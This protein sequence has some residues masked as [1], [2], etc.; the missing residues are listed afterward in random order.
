MLHVMRWSNLLSKK[1]Q[2]NLGRF[3]DMLE[4]WRD[5]GFSSEK[6]HVD[7]VEQVL[8]ESGYTDMLQNEQTPGGRRQVREP[9][10]VGIKLE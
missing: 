8:D 2:E 5:V 7:L 1:I 4:I 10:R 6:N 9:E 3:L